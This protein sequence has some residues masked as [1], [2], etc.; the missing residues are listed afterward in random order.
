MQLDK[1]DGAVLRQMLWGGGRLL[2]DNKAAVNA[3]NVFPVPDGD[4]GTNMCLT[5]AQAIKDTE[6]LNVIT[7]SRVAQAASTGSLMGAR[8][9]SGVILS[10]LIR[11]FAKEAEGKDVLNAK[12]LAAA[13]QSA[14]DTAYQAVIKPV[15]GTILTVAREAAKAA[16][17]AA[18]HGATVTEVMQA[19]ITR[20]QQALDKTPELLPVLK[21]AGVVDAGGQGLLLILQG[22]NQI[23]TGEVTA[24]VV[25]EPAKPPMPE[26]AAPDG[27]EEELAFQYCTE[28]IVSGP[29]LPLEKMREDLARIGD[30][31]LVV[32]AGEVV[33]I[34][35]HTNNPGQVLE[36][37]VKLGTL[38]QV[39]VDNMAKQHREIIN[40]DQ[41]AELAVTTD[42]TKSTGLVAVAVGDGLADILKSLGVDQVIEGGQTMNPSTEE[43]I[44]AV[45]QVAAD[46]VIILPNNS[47]IILTAQQAK[48]LIEKEVVVV[49]S[50]SIP[51][52][53][54]AMIA[55]NPDAELADNEQEML[56]SLKS[57]KSGEVTYAVR[58]CL[59]GDMTISQGDFLGMADGEIAAVTG[60]V[61][62]TALVLVEKMVDDDSELITLYYGQEVSLEEAQHLKASIQET[63]PDCDVELHYGGQPLYY[64]LISVE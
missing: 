54:A 12:D 44:A 23:L 45:N 4:T 5:I 33:K 8:G 42:Q 1:I 64:Y 35:V 21:R 53:I 52:G 6:K 18:R 60:S 22:A 58:D 30:S 25:A 46:Q 47:N 15:E 13:F 31:L 36:Y 51:Q 10:Q 41:P 32:G 9:N 40:D 14:A 17:E 63:Y 24:T 59:I 37:C 16:G 26:P 49:P 2:E 43:I 27:L 39:K 7:V 11:G 61:H 50:K 19:A 3:L 62:D 48:S 28:V 56:S 34:H 38:D 29:G 20:G 57:I 55:F